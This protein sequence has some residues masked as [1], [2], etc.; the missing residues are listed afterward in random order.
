MIPVFFLLIL[1]SAS[2]FAPG[3]LGFGLLP[4]H[5]HAAIILILLPLALPL[6]PIVRNHPWVQKIE[7][8]SRSPYPDRFPFTRP[9]LQSLIVAPILAPILF[10]ALW[11]VRMRVF[12]PPPHGLGDS[13]LLLEH[14]PA[15]SIQFGYLGTFDEILALFWRSRL[16]LWLNQTAAMPAE[17]AI[18]IISCLAGALHGTA[19]FLITSRLKPVRRV[20]A[21]ALLFFVPALQLYA[22]YV[23]NYSLASFFLFLTVVSGV[24]QLERWKASRPV[25]PEW[26]AFFAALGAA[27]HM[28]LVFAFPALVLLVLVLASRKEGNY[29][30]VRW[31]LAASMALRAGSVGLLILGLVWIYFF[32]IIS[33][34]IEL[35][36]SF[37]FRPALYPIRKLIST[38]HFLQ[39]LNI[40]VLCAPAAIGL[41]GALLPSCSIVIARIRAMPTRERKNGWFKAF[42][43]ERWKSLQA[44]AISYPSEAFSLAVFLCFLGHSFIWNPVIGFPADWDLFSFY[45]APLHI[46]LYLRIFVRDEPFPFLWLRRTLLLTVLPCYFWISRNHEYSKESQYNVQQSNRNLVEFLVL[47]QKENIF[48]RIPTLHR[49]RTYIEVRMFAIRARHEIE[50]LPISKEEKALLDSRLMQGLIRFQGIALEPD[51]LYQKQLPDIYYD[52]ADVNARISELQ[53]EY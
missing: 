35:H 47:R 49:Q 37:A 51:E 43:R 34:P 6:E 46:F 45:Q 3:D 40:L 12:L 21:F 38:T 19:V 17:D 39:G 25:Y 1:A 2:L 8:W 7:S 4:F 44:Y 24:V 50:R 31:R 33:N 32:F 41:G 20:A 9:T 36:E 30:S 26:P 5:G 15:H 16:Y 13:L 42:L 22:G 28:V 48:F 52:L 23:E 11:M 18:G 29:L 27:H 10:M 53:T 14:I